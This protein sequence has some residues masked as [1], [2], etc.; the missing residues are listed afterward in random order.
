MSQ[1]ELADTQVGETALANVTG[2]APFRDEADAPELRDLLSVLS[3]RRLVMLVTVAVVF[4][5]GLLYTVLTRPIY[6]S[7]AKMVV[8][9]SRAGAPVTANDVP[10]LS[11][12][13]ALTRSRSVDTQ[14]EVIAGADLLD[15][16]YHA[17]DPRLRGSGFGRIHLPRWA[18]R[19]SNKKNTDVIVVTGRAYNPDAAAALANSIANTYFR[20]DLQENNQATRQARRYAEEKMVVAESDL[21]KANAELSAFKRRTGLFAPQTQ[22]TKTA[23]HVAQMTLELD[24]A[25]TEATASRRETA[26]L[27]QQLRQERPYVMTSTSVTRNPH[28]DAIVDKIQSL[29]SERIALLEEYTPQS[30]EVKAIENRIGQEQGRLKQF[31]QTFVGSTQ[32]AR[33]PVHDTLLARYA[34]DVAIASASTARVRAIQGELAARKGEAQSLPAREQEFN[35]LVGRATLLQRT[36]EM[37][38]TNYYTLLLSEQAMLPNGTLVSRARVSSSPAYPNRMNNAALFLCLGVLAAVVVAIVVERL[39]SHVHDQSAAE[40][41]T[42][43]PTLA[44][45]PVVGPGSQPIIAEGEHNFAL[46]ES[47]RILRNNIAFSGVERP[48]RTLAVTSACRSE[49]KSTVVTNL[50]I[51]TAMDGKR[52]LLV[53]ADMRCSSLHRMVK[54]PSGTGLTTVL[55]GK[56][57]LEDTIVPTTAEGVYCLPAGPTPPN[58]A[59]L[60]NSQPSRELFRQL[61]ESYD[62][63][64]ID[65]PPAL[66]LSDVQVISTIADGV[67]LVV[68]ANETPKPHLHAAMRSLSQIGAPLI[69]LVLN[70][71]DMRRRSYGYGYYYGY[72]DNYGGDRDSSERSI[73]STADG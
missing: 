40:E 27:E 61:A 44:Q 16:A 59:E 18:Y 42:G 38:S 21:A 65:C 72:Y 35:E 41:T 58:P 45:V 64:L 9:G 37:L 28:Y 49:G 53:D 30:P 24:A 1:H 11:D 47:F 7:S 71:V 51:A 50:A 70:N 60:L 68:M 20:R 56:S 25:R 54:S 36:Y 33:N 10:W 13:Q 8:A 46:L 73:S 19:I 15:E 23:E 14:V 34:T 22:I 2:D 17:M 66:G 55:T 3:R 39:D 62:M 48:L 67:V 26:A 69:G 43:L 4:A 5:L 57:K 52:V 6:E 63:V 12:V 32:T 31:T 29:N